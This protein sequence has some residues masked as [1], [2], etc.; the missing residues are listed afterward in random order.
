MRDLDGPMIIGVLLLCGI[1]L[2]MVH[3]TTGGSGSDTS[4]LVVSQLIRVAGGLVIL[5]FLSRASLR[6]WQVIAYPAY[7]VTLII[8]ALVLAV[9][10]TRGGATR[11]ITLGP[12]LL[13]PSE[14][15]KVT[16]PMVL[17]VFLSG[18]S[19]EST[20]RTLG[21]SAL[22]VGVPLFFILLQPDLGT[23]MVL[24]PV[25][26]VM[27]WWA[28]VPLLTLFSLTAPLLSMI[29]AFS[30]V[31]WSGLM[32]VVVVVLRRAGAGFLRFATVIVSCIATGLLTP[33]VWELL[34]EYQKKR[35][36]T[37][38]NP[39]LDPRGSGWNVIQSKIAVGSGKIFGKGLMHG[40]QKGLAFLP[41]Q[42]TDFIFSV[43]GEEFGWVGTHLVLGL[44]F[45]IL[46]RGIAISG[47]CRSPFARVLVLGYTVTIAVE[48]VVNVG[49]TIGLLPVTGLP[50]PFVSYGGSH[51]IAALAMIGIVQSLKRNWK[52]TS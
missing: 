10:E 8:L 2:I 27:L 36:L 47:I 31:S 17:A 21:L 46:W 45:L 49:M 25:V 6:F 41:E 22:I 44:F 12:L 5:L 39:G 43:I 11:W 34:E 38:L 3:S 13:Q 15:A 4:D 30:L 14:L 18:R 9:G 42:H 1:G 37:F 52:E 26:V 28:E 29:C 33:Y 24:V 48:V 20:W 7:S 23:G 51:I 35:I 40:T 32:I 19:R 50:L 16:T